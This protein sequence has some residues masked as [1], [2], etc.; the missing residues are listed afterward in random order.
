MLFEILPPVTF[1]SKKLFFR[2][3]EYA[4]YLVY[5]IDQIH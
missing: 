3:I 5:K 2:F 1:I 4:M